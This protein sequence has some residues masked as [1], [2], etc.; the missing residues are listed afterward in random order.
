MLT[1][2]AEKRLERKDENEN[3]HFVERTY[4]TFQRLLQLPVEVDPEQVQ[5]SFENGVLTVSL[6]KSAGQQ[7]SRRIQVKAAGGNAAG[8][9]TIDATAQG[10]RSERQ[11][12][13]TEPGQS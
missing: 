10:A 12:A 3:F 1:I 9:Q 6:K 4:G 2:R 7:R 13:Q 5:A 8:R 11:G